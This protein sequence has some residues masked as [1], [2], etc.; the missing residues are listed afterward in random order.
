MA[1]FDAVEGYSSSKPSKFDAPSQQLQDSNVGITAEQR[2]TMQAAVKKHLVQTNRIQWDVA[3]EVTDDLAANQVRLGFG[4]VFANYKLEKDLNRETNKFAIDHRNVLRMI[5][6][7]SLGMT[8]GKPELK[9]C[10]TKTVDNIA[11]R[12]IDIPAAS[13]SHEFFGFVAL[14]RYIALETPTLI[15]HGGLAWLLGSRKRPNCGEMI[16]TLIQTVIADERKLHPEDLIACLPSAPSIPVNQVHPPTP[17]NTEYIE[18]SPTIVDQMDHLPQ[19]DDI[20]GY[21]SGSSSSQT[22]YRL[23]DD[24]KRPSQQPSVYSLDIPYQH[25]YYYW[26]ASDAQIY[27]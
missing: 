21:A 22:E 8:Q 20:P 3:K 5:V 19:I 2:A 6:R 9:A 4:P 16:R 7:S 1:N 18:S 26:R 27:E 10:L 25:A 24:R 12:F 13:V 17:A 15:N 23:E 14:L 11:R